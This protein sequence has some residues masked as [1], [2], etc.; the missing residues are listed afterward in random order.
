MPIQSLTN[1]PHAFMKLGVIRKGE[2]Q[3][4]TRKDGTKVE[5]PVDLDHF[6]VTYEPGVQSEELE[7]AFRAAYGERP[8][9]IN[10][11]FAETSIPDV[12][13]A[14]YECHKQGGMLCSAGENESGPYWIFYRD[15]ETSEVLVRG[16]MPV[17]EA[18]ADF[19]LKP[20]RL[21]API[22]K[23]SKGEPQ[24]LEPVGRLQVV[25]PELAHIAVGYFLFRPGSPR[26]IRNISA[27]LGAYDAIAKSMGKT[28]TG[29]PF[30]LRRREEEVTKNIN[31]KLSKGPSWVVHLDAGGDW[32]TKAISMIERLALPD[33]IEAEFHEVEPSDENGPDWS[34]ELTIEA[35][36]LP[37]RAETPKP[38]APSLPNTREELT[39]IFAKEYNAATKKVDAKLLPIIQGNSTPEQIKEA[40]SGI[41]AAVAAGA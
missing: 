25:I 20:I 23:N 36:R 6:R 15:P 27:E 34:D 14:N 22:Y 3:T 38:E 9:E 1:V 40:I 7:K 37:A 32:G 29:I 18:G 10:V 39:K 11:R 35:P 28:I 26:D 19:V 8:R 4:V 30:I 17:G 16:G 13:D 41:R 31:G 24:Y 33:V 2:K 5:K 21:D 12:W